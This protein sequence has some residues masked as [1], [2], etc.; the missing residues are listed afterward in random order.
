MTFPLNRTL[1]F[2]LPMMQGADVE[3]LQAALVRR[4]I[5][6]RIAIDGLYGPGTKA[7]VAI[8]QRQRALVADG[9]A[10]QK[11]F[12]ALSDAGI[13]TPLPVFRSSQNTGTP[14]TVPISGAPQ[15]TASAMVLGQNRL[16]SPSWMPK[17]E[18]KRIILHWTAGAYEPSATDKKHYHILIDGD[19]GLHQGIFSIKDNETTATPYAAHTAKSNSNSIGVSLCAMGGN[20]QER[21]LQAGPFPITRT[22]WETLAQV[23][24]ELCMRYN[25][26]VTRKTVLGHGEVQDILGITQSGKWDPLALEWDPNRPYRDVGDE[27]RRR[28]QE[29]LE[30]LKNPKPTHTAIAASL[31]MAAGTEQEIPVTEFVTINGVALKG[32]SFDGRSWIELTHLCDHMGWPLPMIDPDTGS[33]LITADDLSLRFGVTQTPDQTGFP[34][35]WIEAAELSE[36]L[37]LSMRAD[38]K[39]QLFLSDLPADQKDQAIT[40]ARGQTLTKIAQKYLGDADRWA[41]LMDESGNTFTTESAKRLR[42]GQIILLPNGETKT[43]KKS[44]D[45]PLPNDRIA[46]IARKISGLEGGS[47]SIRK[48]RHDAVV[49]I[50]AACKADGVNDISHQAYILATAYHET[51][52]GQWMREIWG[53]TA[54]QKTYG[55]RLGNRNAAEGKKYLGREFVQITGRNNYEKYGNIYKKDFINQPAQVEAYPMAATILVQGLARFGFTGKGVLSDLGFD[56]DFDFFNARALVNGDKNAKGDSRYPGQKKGQ[57]IAEKARKYREITATT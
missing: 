19:G 1:K 54:A 43:E 4:G 29:I 8:F 34:T 10:G 40:L 41:E 22:Q 45:T 48:V 28:T 7:A 32:A 5:I 11:T 49:A 47:A 26:E 25:I 12:A 21:P 51:N 39:G 56:G 18:M 13:D 3:L 37:G 35:H 14:P 17:A 55:N 36:K 27:I 2:R 46:E 20:V 57:G 31:P 23:A 6:N 9:I 30:D 24:A 44:D 53:P 38:A 42:V 52:L 16:I 33:A 15:T 50:L